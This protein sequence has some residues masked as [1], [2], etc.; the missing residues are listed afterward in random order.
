MIHKDKTTK[1]GANSEAREHLKRNLACSLIK[2]G[3][4]RT[5]ITKAKFV[6]P[7]V[8]KLIT[9]AE[10]DTVANRREICSRLGGDDATRKLFEEIAPRFFDRPGG[11]T[12]ILKLNRRKGDGAE[13]A[14]IEFVE[15]E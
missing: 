15:R 1:L 4:I 13:Q 7:F 2:H 9:R 5:T 8:E 10:N 12:R 6:Q 14:L 3:R 11:Y